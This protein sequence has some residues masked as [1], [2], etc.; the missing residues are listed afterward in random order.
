VA[1]FW[2]AAAFVDSALIANLGDAPENLVQPGGANYD[3]SVLHHNLEISG[4]ASHP[5]PPD[6][7][8]VRLAAPFANH[9]AADRSYAAVAY[10]LR[11]TQGGGHWIALL[12]PSS[13]GL[14]AGETVAAVLCD[15]LQPAPY[16]L[17]FAEAED[18]LT[19]CALEGVRA[20]AGFGHD[21]TW[22]AFLISAQ[23]QAL[24]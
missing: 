17:T 8:Q 9:V 19:A 11:T 22:G 1:A 18:L 14:Q 15:S 10:I 4:L 13:L 12:P 23:G 5:L 3:W 24:D 2:S 6:L 7:L 21:L 16:V 20:D